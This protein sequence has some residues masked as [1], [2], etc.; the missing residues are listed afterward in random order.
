MSNSHRVPYGAAARRRLSAVILSIVLIGL[1]AVAYGQPKQGTDADG[2]GQN[3]QTKIEQQTE[4]IIPPI[5]QNDIERIANAL[6]AAN[7]HPNAVEEQQQARDNL[8]AQ[9]NIAK[10]AKITAM[11]AGIDTL[12][13][14]VGVILVGFTL[15]ATRR[16][17]D[18]AR[19]TVNHMRES[20]HA[21][22]RAYIGI[23]NGGTVFAHEIERIPTGGGVV[24]ERPHMN[25]N[26]A[27]A[28]YTWNY[29][30]TPAKDAAM[31]FHITDTAPAGKFDDNLCERGPGPQIVHPGQSFGKILG[32]RKPIEPFFI[33]GYVDYVDI[34][35]HKWRFRFAYS[36]NFERGRDPERKN[37]PWI[38]H[39]NHNDE[40]DLSELPEPTS[41]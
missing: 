5:T 8:K 17:A 4:P 32:E 37:D 7:I 39:E 24:L 34:F 3:R 28:I 20:T 9:R 21:E 2:N 23:Q 11:I 12:V 22:L 16:A 29:G 15:V 30:K 25:K 13:T 27:V 10:W 19:D 14:I 40:Q 18:A 36:H 38:A 33:Y 26:G 35:N 6:E 31:Y 41:P 1:T